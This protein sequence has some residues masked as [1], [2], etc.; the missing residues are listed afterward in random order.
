MRDRAL[1]EIT[2]DNFIPVYSYRDSTA[3]KSLSWDEQ[4][5]LQNI[6]AQNKEAENALWK[7][8]AL[9]VLTPICK[10]TGM[11][12]CAEDLGVNLACMPEVL[13]SLDI[14]SLKVIRWNRA[15]VK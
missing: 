15:W 11:T 14:L 5:K 13:N 7:K 2:P 12:A 1:I 9:D 3:W 4:Q 10:E 8:Q 6:F